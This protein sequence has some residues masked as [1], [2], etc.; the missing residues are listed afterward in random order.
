[1][2]QFISVVAVAVLDVE[3]TT[4]GAIKFFRCVP[5]INLKYRLYLTFEP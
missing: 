2:R 3:A 4:I 5:K 1:M